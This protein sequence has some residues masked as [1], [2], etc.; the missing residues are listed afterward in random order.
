MKPG[1]F[2]TSFCYSLLV[3]LFLYCSRKN[4]QKHLQQIP[5]AQLAENWN[6][7]CA[8]MKETPVSCSSKGWSW[9]G[10]QCFVTD[11]SRDGRSSSVCCSSFSR[12]T[13]YDGGFPSHQT[14]HWSFPKQV[15]LVSNQRLCWLSAVIYCVLH[16]EVL[17]YC[18]L[19]S[20]SF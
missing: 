4:S 10:E 11:S 9:S 18:L 20:L 12:E 5:M 13:A 14:V 16:G 2:L 7:M 6:G 8:W 17:F 1:F 19:L 15:F 3:L